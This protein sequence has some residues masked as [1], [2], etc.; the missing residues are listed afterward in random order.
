MPLDSL[1]VGKNVSYLFVGLPEVLWIEEIR[2]TRLVALQ[3]FRHPRWCR[4]PSINSMFQGSLRIFF[5][6]KQPTATIDRHHLQQLVPH[7]LD[8]AEEG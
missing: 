1:S 2:L 5:R 6:V 7:F 3:G 8:V 4:I